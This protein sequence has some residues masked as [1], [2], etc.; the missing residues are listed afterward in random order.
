MAHI[1][2]ET[3]AARIAVLNASNLIL[4]ST[5]RRLAEEN[6][7]T[8]ADWAHAELARRELALNEYLEDMRGE[9]LP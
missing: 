5:L 4:A 2:D 3:R 7:G 8:V 9:K 6:G 1:T